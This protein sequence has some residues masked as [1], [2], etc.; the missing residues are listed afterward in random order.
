[1]P[2]VKSIIALAYDLSGRAVGFQCTES[3]AEIEKEIN[4]AYSNDRL[5]AIQTVD[6]L[7]LVN[8]K[9][10]ITISV[11]NAVASPIAI[12]GANDQKFKGDKGVQ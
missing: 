11:K 2:Q 1:M 12:V 7:V 3:K 9:S 10:P 4:L 8:V 6:E 5:A